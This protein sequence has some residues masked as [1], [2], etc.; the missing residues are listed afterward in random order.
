MDLQ[1]AFELRSPPGMTGHAVLY[2]EMLDMAAWADRVGFS[3]VN[4]GEHHAS[5]SGYNPSPLITCAGVAGRTQRI[6][7][8]PNILIAPLYDP[9]KLAED[10]AVLSLVSGGRFDICLGG[11]YRPKECA[12]FDKPI[13]GR[14]KAVGEAARVLKA[15]W[16]GEPFDYEGRTVTIRPIPERAP[17]LLIGGMSPAAAKRAARIG[18]GF[19]SPLVPGLWEHYRDAAIELGKPDPGPEQPRGPVFL[20]VAEDVDAAWD[21]LMP[22]VLSQID[23]YASFTTE[24]Y[25]EPVGPYAGV[26]DAVAAR[27][28]PAYQVL[29]PEELIELGH[30]LGPDGYL[31]FNPLM[32]AIPPQE[33]WRMLKLLERRVMPHLPV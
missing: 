11:G 3:F 18:D 13:N 6:R 4:F 24:G 15:A 14:W 2:S 12:M 30:T 20:W 10:T 32:G 21:M 19:S 9:I 26:T 8:R 25:G 16:T 23:E 17:T 27:A 33:A 22:H 28:N 31:L 29:T 5:I 1:L 7:M